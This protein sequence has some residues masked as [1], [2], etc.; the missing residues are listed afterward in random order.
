MWRTNALVSAFQILFNTT[1]VLWIF[2][3][4]KLTWVGDAA[5]GWTL[6]K[7]IGGLSTSQIIFFQ[8]K[9]NVHSEQS[10][11]FSKEYW[12]LAMTRQNWKTQM[13]LKQPSFSS[14]NPR[15]ATRKAKNIATMFSVISL[16]LQKW[17]NLLVVVENKCDVHKNLIIFHQYPHLS[18]NASKVNRSYNMF[19]H[20]PGKTFIL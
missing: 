17:N 10:N 19:T 11:T 9:T 1:T 4:I 3:K 18:N 14:T 2:L 12:Q 5:S 20:F 15:K 7:N 8:Q 6:Y 16:F 13:S